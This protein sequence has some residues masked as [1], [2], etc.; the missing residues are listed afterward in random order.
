MRSP[1]AMISIDQTQYINNFRVSVK[2]DGPEPIH[3]PIGNTAMHEAKHIVAAVHNGTH[4]RRAT[5]SPGP[6]YLG[7]TELSRPDAV[8][9][10]AP[11]ATG[12]SGTGHDVHIVGAMGHDLDSVSSIAR[13]IIANNAEQVHAVASALEAKRTIGG[14]DVQEAMDG[15]RNKK[16]SS[17]KATLF[18]KAPDGRE[19]VA[20]VSVHNDKIMLPGEWI[21]VGVE[22]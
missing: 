13:S 8:A 5:I 2:R 12:C 22:S 19:Q 20:S 4:V 18:V 7:L 16:K 14:Y 9:A 1:E 6:G 10:A 15:V 11:H 3:T 17:E 21:M